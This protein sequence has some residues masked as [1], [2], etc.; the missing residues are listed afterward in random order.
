M[1]NI[2]KYTQEHCDLVSKIDK[3]QIEMQVS[4][5]ASMKSGN[6]MLSSMSGANCEKI[7]SSIMTSRSIL[8]DSTK[9][10]Q[11]KKLQSQPQKDKKQIQCIL[12]AFIEL[13]N[14]YY[15]TEKAKEKNTQKQKKLNQHQTEKINK[16]NKNLN[17]SIEILLYPTKQD[18]K[19]NPNK[20]NKS[21]YNISLENFNNCINDICKKYK[22]ENIEKLIE[23]LKD[24]NLEKFARQIQ[25]FQTC[26]A[27]IEIQETFM[28][29]GL[30][31]VY[32]N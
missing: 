27:A 24:T 20:E 1:E 18:K 5:L 8:N 11:D 22:V 9:L 25:S 4:I 17:K 6:S 16:V 15:N 32:F 12:N 26:C 7:A 31:A 10:L 30:S 28:E 13:Y 3:Q 2:N 21:N 14:N 23:V 19:L 29:N